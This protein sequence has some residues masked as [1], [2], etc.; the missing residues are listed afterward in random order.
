MKIIKKSLILILVIITIMQSLCFAAVVSDNDGSAFITK[1]EFDSLK[2]SFQSQLDSYN[3][4]IDNKIDN[5]IASYLAGIK[6]DKAKTISTGFIL[7]GKSNKIIFVGRKN[8]FNNM[9]NVLYTADRIF[10]IFCGTYQAVAYYIQDTYDTFAFEGSHTKGNTSNYLFAID[11]NSFA[12]SSKKN[13]QMN[14][15]RIYVGY[16]TTN[17]NNGMFWGSIA[18]ELNTPDSITNQSS[19]YISTTTAKGYGMRRLYSAD[20]Y[21]IALTHRMYSTNGEPNGGVDQGLWRT[22][23]ETKTMNDVV[24]TCDVAITGTDVGTNLHWPQGSQYNIKT[25]NKEWGSKD[26]IK[27]YSTDRVDYTYTYKLRNSGGYAASEVP[28]NFSPTIKGYGLDWKTTNNTFSNIFYSGI[29]SSWKKKYAYSGGLPLCPETNDGTFE[30]TFSV[31]AE[32]EIAFSNAQNEAFPNTGNPRF[33]KCKVKVHGSTS[34]YQEMD[35]SIVLTPGTYDFKVD[36]QNESL[37]L[38]AYMNDSTDTVE[39]TQIGDAKVTEKT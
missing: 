15:S 19:A 1:A 34:E 4:N 32:V 38:M 37:F 21:T 28:S 26:I 27:G 16:S 11:E 25:I 20:P 35:T 36:L 2:N 33:K 6:V 18:Q 14:A 17:A 10:E 29:N 8:N 9:N 13:C 24:K 3:Q 7:E 31:N 23:L 22:D 30:I 5:A 12:L 39:F